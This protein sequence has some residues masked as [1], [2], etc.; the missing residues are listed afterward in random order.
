[1]GKISGQNVKRDGG[2]E[3]NSLYSDEKSR[4]KNVAQSIYSRIHGRINLLLLAP[5]S[6]MDDNFF[7]FGNRVGQE[8]LRNGK[9]REGYRV[10]SETK[11]TV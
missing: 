9:D 1:M 6:S 10:S 2:R 8:E 7:C 4:G 11:V 5:F 3:G